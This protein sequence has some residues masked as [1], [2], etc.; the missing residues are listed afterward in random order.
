MATAR[1][2]A[3][4]I[5]PPL[6]IVG[7]LVVVWQLYASL[8]GMGNDVLPTPYRVLSVTWDNRGDLWANTL[9]TLRATLL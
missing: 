6:L 3:L 9:P 1:S 5:L 7:A 2:R 4:Q 8:R